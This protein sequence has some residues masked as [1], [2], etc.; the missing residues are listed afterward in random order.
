MSGSK[1]EGSPSVIAGVPIGI[2]KGGTTSSHYD[3]E[4][5]SRKADAERRRAHQDT[6][7]AMSGKVTRSGEAA[8]LGSMNLISSASPRLVLKYLNRD[9]TVRQEALAEIT[10]LPDPSNP[11]IIDV[12]FSMVCPRCVA[13]GVEQG[14][15]QLMIRNSHRKWTLDERK[16][17]SIVMVEY[18]YPGS[19][20]FRKPVVIAGEVTV[21][22]IVKC[23]NFN[24]DFRCRIDKSN[25]Y[26]V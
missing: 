25:V 19:V 1:G 26:E 23:D 20:P 18:H 24:C 22:D 3:N 14:Q 4:M 9:K 11:I 21:E 2:V 10:T 13:R 6:A 12:M 7:A 17:G 16:K 8:R 5:A 15:A